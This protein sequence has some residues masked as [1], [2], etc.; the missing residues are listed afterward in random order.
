MPA[1]TGHQRGAI[2]SV[3]LAIVHVAL[4]AAWLSRP[5]WHAALMSLTQ[6]IEDKPAKERATKG[7]AR[8]GR[9]RR[10]FRLAIEAEWR[11][12]AAGV[13]PAQPKARPEG[14]RPIGMPLAPHP[15]FPK[16]TLRERIACAFRTI[17]G[18]SVIKPTGKTSLSRSFS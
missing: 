5:R 15:N 2:G 17:L 4:H 12:H 1:M 11:K 14:Q 18:K 13:V 8:D 9:S 10:H 16:L 6:A 3:L 7:L